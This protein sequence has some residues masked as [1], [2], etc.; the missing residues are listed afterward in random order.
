MSQQRILF[1]DIETAPMLA[2][3]WQAKTDYVQPHQITHETYM[4][5]WAAK[6]AHQKQVKS[7]VL[8]PAEAKKQV[9]TRIV[10]SLA[11][12][13]R[14]ADVV[15]GHNLDRFDIPMVNNRL[16]ILEEE[17][18]GPIRT[19][20]TLKLAR[21]AFR[22]ASNRLDYLARQMGVGRKIDTSFDLWRGCYHG[23][24]KA[25][26]KMVRY[27]R[28]DVRVLED[29]YDRMRPYV[30]GVPRLVDANHRGEHVCPTCG[31]SDLERRGF[32]HTNASVFQRYR[33]RDCKRWSR[34]ASREKNAVLGT[35]P[36]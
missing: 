4:L 12:M 15:V 7:D 6:W 10:V 33:C 22:L 28:Q 26:S 2:Y 14:E 5:S 18:L 34:A 23:E 29:V 17:P 21:G 1:F 11:D 25:L 3:V 36:L 8:R 13:L 24:Q 19:I 31:G 27:N 30:K 9:D 32:Y 35:R 20:D 16:M